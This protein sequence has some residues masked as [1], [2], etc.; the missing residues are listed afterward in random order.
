[1]PRRTA[2]SWQELSAMW[3]GG[4]SGPVQFAESVKDGTNLRTLPSSRM[5]HTLEPR[6]SAEH[7]PYHTTYEKP[8]SQ[9]SA[10]RRLVAGH[11]AWGFSAGK[12][13]PPR[14]RTRPATAPS[15]RRAAPATPADPAQ[16]LLG[17]SA[18]RRAANASAAAGQGEGEPTPALMAS[19]LRGYS[20][21]RRARARP[22]ANVRAYDVSGTGGGARAAGAAAPSTPAAAPKDAPEDDDD[23]IL[24]RLAAS[25]EDQTNGLPIGNAMVQVAAKPGGP[26]LL[27]M[28]TT[29]TGEVVGVLKI[30]APMK[31]HLTATHAQFAT[32]RRA[33]ALGKR[34]GGAAPTGGGRP[35]EGEGPA[36]ASKHVMLKMQPLEIGTALRVEVIELGP[37]GASQ[38]GELSEGGGGSVEGGGGQQAEEHRRAHPRALHGVDVTVTVEHAAEPIAGVGADGVLC[39]GQ[40]ST[41]GVCAWHLSLLHAAKFRV[42]AKRDGFRDASAV[43]AL[44]QGEHGGS[45]A[46]RLELARQHAAAP[47]VVRVCDG[48]T[49]RPLHGARVEVRRAA[50]GEMAA[51]GDTDRRGE[52]RG[53]LTACNGSAPTFE[54]KVR[55]D[56]WHGATATLDLS[57]AAGGKPAELEITLAPP[58]V[59]ALTV[60]VV[61]AE[62]D[63]RRPLGGARVVLLHG[64]TGDVHGRACSSTLRGEA[65]LR[66]QSLAPERLVVEVSKEGWATAQAA[67]LSPA[68]RATLEALATAS[69]EAGAAATSTPMVARVVVELSRTA[70]QRLGSELL[71]AIGDASAPAGLI[72]IEPRRTTLREVRTRLRAERLGAL[73]PLHFYFELKGAAVGVESE[74]RHLAAEAMDSNPPVLVLR[75]VEMVRAAVKLLT[76]RNL[77]LKWEPPPAMLRQMLEARRAARASMRAAKAVASASAA[78]VPED[79]GLGGFVSFAD[80]EERA[81][82]E[83]DAT[84]DDDK[85]DGG[86]SDGDGGATDGMGFAVELRCGAQVEE[87][88]CSMRALLGNRS[89]RERE[90]ATGAGE[91][92]LLVDS[93]A[94]GP[95]QQG[96]Q[97]DLVVR[98][99]LPDRAREEVAPL[100]V[101]VPMFYGEADAG[102][103]GGGD[104]LRQAAADAKKHGGKFEAF[105]RT[106]PFHAS[107][108]QWR[109]DSDADETLRKIAGLLKKH[110]SIRLQVRG[111]CNGGLDNLNIEEELSWGR[112]ANVCEFLVAAGAS[113]A[114]LE[115][116]GKACTQQLVPPHSASSWK[117]RRVD[118]FPIWK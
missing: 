64:D 55:L 76:T 25:V 41:L 72:N 24:V 52:L 77:V 102:G 83:A 37:E 60:E 71:V 6:L 96:A 1:M 63:A 93:F 49:R 43:F 18:R 65:A 91:C 29:A 51:L 103:S 109:V 78:A 16:R 5:P 53:E 9:R 42:T 84:A 85:E 36:R 38:T 17:G 107:S 61:G 23:G 8:R 26:P 54:V 15:K 28:R 35:R 50:D 112:A 114:Q 19:P 97:Y 69:A 68:A 48:A 21:P 108:T 30:P 89:A 110:P 111:H 73:M 75:P 56:G 70:H 79:G 4:D 104:P 20:P 87:R 33:A 40:T 12:V 66:M 88:K 27:A 86:G 116:D 59:V 118:F 47:A 13:R 117:N 58:P 22:P 115:L 90:Q 10:T 95:L 62:V 100:S 101:R 7:T 14:W 82:A 11:S 98:S 81:Q 92:E 2:E 80:D 34:G 67:A 57:S 39:A 113:A 74:A 106:I 105:H 3:E 32:L 99:A 94:G 31:L 44:G 45:T 46:L